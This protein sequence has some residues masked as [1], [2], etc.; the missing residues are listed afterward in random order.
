[1]ELGEKREVF[2]TSRSIWRSGPEIDMEKCV[3]ASLEKQQKRQA[4][5][6]YIWKRVVD[7]YTKLSG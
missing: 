4:R 2:Y 5:A 3:D 1:M 6:E 7:D